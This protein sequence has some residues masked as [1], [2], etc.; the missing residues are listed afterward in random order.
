MF[1][2]VR[3]QGD[4]RRLI[5]PI[6]ERIHA[7]DPTLPVSDT[8]LMKEHLA[9]AVDTPRH[10]TLLVGGFALIAV[11]LAALGVFGVMSYIV[12]QQQREIGVRLALG[13]APL[14]VLGLV[15]RRGLRLAGIGT[16]AGLVAAVQ[17]TRFIQHVLFDVSATDP[18][19][20]AGVAT[21]LLII[22]TVAC[23]FPGRR[24]SKVDPVRVMTAE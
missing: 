20:L 17:G 4:P 14:S 10:W 15:L 8:E 24:A 9:S 11:V 19:T 7:V 12:Q 1:L 6:R 22:A 18:R 23:Y 13:A 21:L 16:F 5:E 3:G 2:V